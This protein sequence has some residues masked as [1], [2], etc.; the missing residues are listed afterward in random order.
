MRWI[1]ELGC[2]DFLDVC[3]GEVLKVS[4]E[5][6]QE[7]WKGSESRCDVCELDL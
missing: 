2:L 1:L 5:K 3:V 6:N 7:T 4:E